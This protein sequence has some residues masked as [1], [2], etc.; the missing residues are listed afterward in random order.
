MS[1]HAHDHL[2]PDKEAQIVDGAALVFAQDGYEG[3]S[4]SRIAAEAGVSKGTLYNYFDG[5]AE[6]FAAY[7][8]RECD[9]KIVSLLDDMQQGGAPDETL[10]RIGRRMMAVMLSGSGLIMYRMVIAEA[11]KFPELARIFYEAGPERVIAH[12]TTWIRATADAGHLIVAD[13]VFASEQL[14]ALMQTQLCMKR[15]LGLIG[16][17]SQAAIDH[18]VDA[19]VAMFMRGYG[20]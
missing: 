18:I 17:P 12:M 20:T 1:A 5:K 4:M 9:R 13:P 6:L 8:R 19:A 2:S 14:F 15:R 11:P 10:R 16:E 7:V 3:A